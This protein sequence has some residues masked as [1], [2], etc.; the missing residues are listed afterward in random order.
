MNK[1][2]FSLA[3]LTS[4][5]S[6]MNVSS[7]LQAACV[8]GDCAAMGYTKTES[9]CEGDIIRC[10]FDTSKVFCK[11]VEPLAIGDLLFSDKTTGKNMVEG[12]TVIGVVV[13]TSRR[14]AAYKIETN[15]QW[16]KEGY[17]YTQMDVPNLPNLTNEQAKTDFNG[18][19]N[20]AALV[21]A[22]TSLY[23]AANYCNNLTTEG[24]SKGDW[25]L[26][27]AGELL[28]MLN[29]FQ[30]MNIGFARAAGTQLTS[31]YN[32]SEYNSS[33]E[34]SYSECGGDRTGYTCASYVKNNTGKD[35]NAGIDPSN[36]FWYVWSEGPRVRCFIKF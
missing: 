23:P 14:L 9:A 36:K 32:R 30:Q 27:A 33:T 6:L 3:L 20:T 17:Q 5:V 4:A 22:S 13:D 25:Y 16:A 19:S 24:T 8:N 28:L 18:K 7:S 35:N 21:A 34:T 11:E 31:G 15:R 10:P 26:P 1:Y 2:Q 12:K 29:N